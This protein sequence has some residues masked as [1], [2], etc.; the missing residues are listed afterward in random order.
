MPWVVGALG[1]PTLLKACIRDESQ[2]IRI[3]LGSLVVCWPVWRSGEVAI[4]GGVKSAFIIDDVRQVL[5][6]N[7]TLLLHICCY[8]FIPSSHET[9]VSP[10]GLNHQYAVCVTK[11]TSLVLVALLPAQHTLDANLHDNPIVSFRAHIPKFLLPRCLIINPSRL[12]P[13]PSPPP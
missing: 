11:Q 3:F 5:V 8:L 6:L 13:L 2:R 1:H 10:P 4:S 12:N 9:C 7:F